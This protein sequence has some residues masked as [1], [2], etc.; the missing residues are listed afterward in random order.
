V[1]EKLPSTG[2]RCDTGDML[3]V[4]GVFRQAFA[5][6]PGLVAG[7]ADGDKARSAVVADYAIEILDGLHRHHSTEDDY[8]WD[9]LAAKAPACAQHVDLMRAQHAEV[10]VIIDALIPRI[11]AWRASA[12]AEQRAVVLNG[13]ESIRDT[14]AMHL[15]DEESRILPVAA[16]TFT[17]P[18]W[19]VVGEKAR[20][21]IPKKRLLVSLGY[22]LHSLPD[23]EREKWSKEML[24]GP[25]RLLWRLVGRHQFAAE[26]RKVF[27]TEP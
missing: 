18:E 11:S 17:Q 14:L 16:T 24:P 13:V 20:S 1:I 21:E 10:A 15:G 12:S 6:M 23:G 9:A 3:V 26:Y 25:A 8:L 7:V 19:D 27:Q 2:A 22:I 5:A 4:H